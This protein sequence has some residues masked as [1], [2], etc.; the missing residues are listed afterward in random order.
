VK[1]ALFDDF[2]SPWSVCRPIRPGLEGGLSA[3]V[4]MVVM[5]PA[6]GVMEVCMLPATNRAFTRFA[7]DT[8]SARAA[9]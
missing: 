4:A 6:L 9:A 2:E 3:S 1:A 8:K 7:L 5:Q